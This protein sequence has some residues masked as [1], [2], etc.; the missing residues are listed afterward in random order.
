M[1]NV[2]YDPFA[3]GPHA[4]GVRTL[5]ITDPPRSRVFACEV[6]YPA[7]TAGP[8]DAVPGGEHRD[9]PAPAGTHPLVVYSHHSVGSSRA[10][11][12]LTRHLASHGYVV[13][14]PD[15]SGVTPPVEGEQTP[16]A[17]R[18]RVDAIVAAR[19]PD[20][21]TVLDRMLAGAARVDLDPEHV[22]LVGHSFGGWTVLAA[23]D[24]EPRVRAVVAHSPGG[25][26]NP[27]PGI[28]PLDLDFAWGHEVPTLYLAAED[29]V[30]IP[31]EQV[32]D[33]FDRTPGP[34][35]MITLRRADHL[36]FIDNV[37]TS[38]EALRTMTLPGDAAWIPAAMRPIGEL[39][40]GAQAHLFVRGLTLA[41]LDATLRSNEGARAL[42]A[43]GVV[44]ELAARGVEATAIVGAPDGGLSA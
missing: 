6:W 7:D 24:V 41:H 1:G 34:T 40:T 39:C 22:G 37:E 2:E 28:L 15:H 4:V 12:F 17:H 14:A 27:R 16:D 42:L 18:A 19:V 20:V 21:R 38:H 35:R 33:V 3:P 31:P 44:A 5:D 11:T 13:A 30:S 29:D 36:H 43:G 8:A 9:A 32:R 10:A 26:K 25:S 23:P